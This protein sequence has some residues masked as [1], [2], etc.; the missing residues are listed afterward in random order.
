MNV[1]LCQLEARRFQSSRQ[2][3]DRLHL[4]RNASGLT[5]Y[6]VYRQR[7]IGQVTTQ[8]DAPILLEKPFSEQFCDRIRDLVNKRDGTNRNIRVVSA[9]TRDNPAIVKYLTKQRLSW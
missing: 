5:Y 4:R 7:M 3:P 6:I 2:H 1:V 9:P 8:P